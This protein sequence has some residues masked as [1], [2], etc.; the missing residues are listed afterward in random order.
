MIDGADS[1]HRHINHTVSAC[2]EKSYMLHD[3]KCSQPHD[4]TYQFDIITPNLE[5]SSS[6]CSLKS[7]DDDH[8][9]YYA[10][11]VAMQRVQ[12]QGDRRC[13][14]PYCILYNQAST[15]TYRSRL[16]VHSRLPYHY[17]IL[18]CIFVI[19][20][21]RRDKINLIRSQGL[22]TGSYPQPHSMGIKGY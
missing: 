8:M 19:N 20:L 6:G 13:D 10:Y 14:D 17:L 3:E 11:I 18:L 2:D 4:H 7:I 9:R 21:S 16:R 1:A 22:V 12:P 5:H 15:H